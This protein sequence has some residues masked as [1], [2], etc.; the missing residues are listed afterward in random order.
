[1]ADMILVRIGFPPLSTLGVVKAVADDIPRFVTLEREF[2]NGSNRKSVTLPNGVVKPGA[3][4]PAGLYL[5]KRVISPRFGDTFEVWGVPGRSKILWHWG[6]I[7]DDSHGCILVGNEFEPS[8]GQTD[9]ILSSKDA[10]EEFMRL[11][12]DVM[13]FQLSI[14]NA[15]VQAIP[16]TT[17]GRHA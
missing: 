6:N 2:D 10:F 5:C 13:S 12:R 14:I 8:R 9:A 16:Q 11:Q 7:A 1:M 17:G 4:I 3:C 15:P